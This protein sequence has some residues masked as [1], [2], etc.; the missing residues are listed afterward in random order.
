[1]PRLAAAHRPI[2]S[3]EAPLGSG[4]TSRK[5]FGSDNHAGTHEAVLRTL[6]AANRGDTMATA[7]THGPSG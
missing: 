6:A 7:T 1:M 2:Q 4:V 3:E 5:S